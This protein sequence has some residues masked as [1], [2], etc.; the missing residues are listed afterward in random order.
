MAKIMVLVPNQEMADYTRQLVVEENIASCEVEV[1]DTASSVVAARRAIEQGA[2][3]IVARG[4][5]AAL[6][7]EYTKIPLVEITLTGQEMGLLIQEAKQM[8][9][10]VRPVVAFVGHKTMFPDTSYMDEI[11]QVNLHMY[12]FEAR[13]QIE[14]LVEKAVEEGADVVIGGEKVLSV[15][16]NYEIPALF[17]R[18]REDSIR[19]ALQ[20]ADKVIYTSREIGRAHV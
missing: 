12:G 7:R 10:N 18:A 15:M 14:G 13:S 20:V 5:Q 8:V 16:Q 19:R 4:L 6:I 9:Q 2:G 11:F 17:L 3:V 1:I